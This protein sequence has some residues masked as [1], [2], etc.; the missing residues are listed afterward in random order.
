MVGLE[1]ARWEPEGYLAFREG[2]VILG[3]SGKE[4]GVRQGHC[5]WVGSQGH[6]Q[7]EGCREMRA[8]KAGKSETEGLKPPCTPSSLTI[9]YRAGS[10]PSLHRPL[11]TDGQPSTPLLPHLHM[12]PAV[13]FLEKPPAWRERDAQQRVRRTGRG[14]QQTGR[15]TA[16]GRYEKSVAT[17]HR[18]EQICCVHLVGPHRG[19]PQGGGRWMER[20]LCIRRGKLQQKVE[21]DRTLG[22]GGRMYGRKPLEPAWTLL[23]ETGRVDPLKMCKVPRPL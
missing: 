7:V 9:S 17:R 18:R 19:T 15:E 10:S 3:G 4:V 8:P 12:A 20:G 11:R 23:V 22:G 1:E 16:Q 6:P 21:S 5:Q 13:K 14:L 2:A